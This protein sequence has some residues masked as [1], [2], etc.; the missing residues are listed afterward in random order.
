MTTRHV[1][2]AQFADLLEDLPEEL[3]EAVIRGVRSAA[4]RLEG[5][6]VQE[7]RT[8]SPFPA[9]ATGELAG[10]VVTTRVDDGAI[11]KVEAPHAPFM[12]EGTRPHF[13]PLQPLQDW[14]R[15]KGF[16]SDEGS[17]QRIAYAVALKIAR[18]G[19]A[20]RHFFKKAMQRFE[21]ILPI[22][23]ARELDRVG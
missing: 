13:P 17:V 12:E 2:P 9:V 15:T 11:V 18:D 22:E 10:S 8:A 16:A 4:L 23:I 14:V 1:T 3:T 19:I 5:F 7:I 6:V 20:P 21:P